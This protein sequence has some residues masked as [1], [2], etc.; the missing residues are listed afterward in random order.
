MEHSFFTFVYPTDKFITLCD[1]NGLSV[2]VDSIP[3][4]SL[5]S[6]SS[7][8]ESRI[9]RH[10]YECQ[11]HP[12]L[13]PAQTVFDLLECWEVYD[14][15]EFR[16]NRIL[17]TSSLGGANSGSLGFID[18]LEVILSSDV[19]SE[20]VGNWYKKRAKDRDSLSLSQ[21]ATK[22]LMHA[23]RLRKP[24]PTVP[25]PPDAGDVYKSSTVE[26]FASSSIEDEID[27]VQVVQRRMGQ[28]ASPDLCRISLNTKKY[29]EFV[30]EQLGA[31]LCPLK[32]TIRPFSLSDIRK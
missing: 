30:Q 7:K 14:I 27:A 31:T 11:S 6:S 26:S 28:S 21:R 18:V 15:P 25:P 5:P 17:S 32:R 13:Y 3:S 2:P 1:S 12:R 24:S 19:L 20:R 29:K 22:L 16:Q 9:S 4:S 8:G 10:W 23:F